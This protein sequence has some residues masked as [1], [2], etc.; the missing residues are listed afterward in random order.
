MQPRDYINLVLLFLLL[1]GLGTTV[2]L[3]QL[4][5]RCLKRPAALIIG[6]VGQF[7]FLPPVAYGVTQ[8][9]AL[10]SGYAAGLVI[11]CCCPGGALSN[12]I[13]FV[14]QADVTMSVAMTAASSIVACGMLPLN[15]LIYVESTNLAPSA[16]LNFLNIALT[17]C[18]V[19]AGTAAGLLIARQGNARLLASAEVTGIVSAVA[20]LVT[21][22][23]NNATSKNP[24]WATPGRA[25]VACFL[26][27]VIGGTAA[28]A[29][30][31]ACRI[32]WPS[33][34]AVGIEVSTQNKL[35]AVAVVTLTLSG[36]D[37]DQAF[38]MPLIYATL[39]AAGNVC[40]GIVAWKMGLTNLDRKA[41]LR[42]IWQRVKDHW[43]RQQPGKLV[44]N[45]MQAQAV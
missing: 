9:F 41:T 5:E 2:E 23:I 37:E 29:A 10:E 36:D 1:L 21:S 18:I 32:A 22:F 31:R 43:R 44:A 7:L 3:E 33:C 16:S 8:L 39:A 15:L 42:S 45:E 4:K 30:A 13:C 12:I 19:V 27:S 40:W 14:V 28:L 24:I 26:T 25:I 38:V 20:L 17:A 35:I 11:M 34:V 6:L